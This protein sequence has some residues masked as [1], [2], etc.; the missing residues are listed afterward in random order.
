[1]A[2]IKKN[3]ALTDYFV[4]SDATLDGATSAVSDYEA[5]KIITFP[6][7]KLSVDHDFWASLPTNGGPV[8]KKLRIAGRQP[9]VAGAV[10]EALRAQMEH[11]TRDI[12]RQI[13]PVYDALFAPYRFQRE[14][15]VLRLNQLVGLSMHIDSYA[16]EIPTHHARMFINLDSQ[17]RIW[18][19]SYTAD[20]I[21]DHMGDRMT[22][23]DHERLSPTDWWNALRYKGLAEAGPAECWDDNPRH[24]CVFEPGDVWVVDSR[25]IAHQIFY[26]RRAMTIDFTVDRASMLDP[27]R[28]YL[29]TVDRLR[30]MALATA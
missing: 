12:Y 17:A 29:G 28:H 20:Q 4:E 1:M 8:F 2:I 7:L 13:M 24:V 6:K 16:D 25:Q 18:Q 11:H 30:K 15:G 22:R 9:S 23:D 14:L 10:E 26:G 3:P 21:V 27:G 5:G 19:T